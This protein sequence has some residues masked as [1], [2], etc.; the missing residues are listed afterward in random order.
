MKRRQTLYKATGASSF[1]PTYKLRSST[2][3]RMEGK[4]WPILLHQSRQQEVKEK[5]DEDEPS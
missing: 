5:S 4:T 2:S 3:L 1:P